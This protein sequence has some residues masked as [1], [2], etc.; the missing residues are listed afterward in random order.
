MST[1]CGLLS[2]DNRKV[3]VAGYGNFP[4]KWVMT[5]YDPVR[6]NILC[7]K[8][9]KQ[10]LGRE[11]FDTT[12]QIIYRVFAVAGQKSLNV[13]P[14]KDSRNDNL[15]FGVFAL[16]ALEAAEQTVDGVADVTSGPIS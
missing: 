5:A 16:E 13:K 4:G 9:G 3:V 2:A 15:L 8:L 12:D 10:L 14:A 1:I 11:V 6:G 7:H